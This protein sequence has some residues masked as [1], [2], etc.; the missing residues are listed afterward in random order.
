MLELELVV[1]EQ[2]NL[3]CA[4]HGGALDSLADYDQ[5]IQRA[6]AASLCRRTPNLAFEIVNSSEVRA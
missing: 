1:L 3:E 4:A 5:P 6:V 2:E